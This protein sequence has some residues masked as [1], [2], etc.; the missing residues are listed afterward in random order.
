MNLESYICTCVVVWILKLWNSLLEQWTQYKTNPANWWLY[1]ALR[2]ETYW[3]IPL[4]V[5]Q[6]HWE[7]WPTTY[8]IIL[9]HKDILHVKFPPNYRIASGWSILFQ[10]SSWCDYLSPYVT[11]PL[12]K[13]LKELW[14]QNQNLGLTLIAYAS[15]RLDC[16]RLKCLVQS[17]NNHD[18]WPIADPLLSGSS[19]TISSSLDILVC[20]KE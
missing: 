18:D 13:R 9:Y 8:P 16:V 3:L 10:S 12:Q 19:R 7:H 20:I 17:S 2:R 6:T 11:I 5:I 4:M 14:S 1:M 15:G